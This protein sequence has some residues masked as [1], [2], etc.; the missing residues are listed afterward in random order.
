MEINKKITIQSAV[1]NISRA[2][3]IG[4]LD[5]EDIYFYQILSDYLSFTKN[6]PKMI[7]EHNSIAEMMYSIKTKNPELICNFKIILPKTAALGNDGNSIPLSLVKNNN[8]SSS[9][10]D[11]Y[12]ITKRTLFGTGT[13]YDTYMFQKNDFLSKYA[14]SNDN[15]FTSIIL[16]GQQNS[17]NTGGSFKYNNTLD[18]GNVF[19][20][21]NTIEIGIDDIEKWGFYSDS[22]SEYIHTI[23]FKFTDVYNGQKYYSPVHTLT[24]YRNDAE[25]NLPPS[26]GDY[27]TTIEHGETIP[28]SLQSVT[29]SLAPPYNDPEGDLLD[30][31]RIVEIST[32]NKGTLLFNGIPVTEMQVFTRQEIEQNRLV[33]QSGSYEDIWGDSFR[34]QGRDEGNGT[35]VD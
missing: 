17:N 4:K 21:G 23:Y 8:I 10:I 35:W 7:T 12:S 16:L 32:A 29:T 28:I 33:Y 11:V 27:S 25:G 26:F 9:N 5:M 34:F 6:D 15:E 24:V 20:D 30:A 19:G 1:K 13:V 2:K 22:T 18:S 3:I 31:I 14:D